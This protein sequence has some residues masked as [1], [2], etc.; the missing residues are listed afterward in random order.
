MNEKCSFYAIKE[1]GSLSTAAIIKIV[2]FFYW[3]FGP[4]KVYKWHNL[5]EEF[6]LCFMSLIIELTNYATTNQDIQK[7]CWV[8]SFPFFFSLRSS[9]GAFHVSFHSSK[10][11]LSSL[12][13]HDKYWKPAQPWHFGT[14][15]LSMGLVS[16]SWRCSKGCLSGKW[17]GGLL[18]LASGWCNGCHS[19]LD[20]DYWKQLW[21]RTKQR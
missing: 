17:K 20:A 8:F 19:I 10:C 11:I 14:D 2:S 16:Q 15:S 18:L 21:H 6:I 12:Q 9:D 13:L 4:V 5:Q 7:L 1:D 3:R